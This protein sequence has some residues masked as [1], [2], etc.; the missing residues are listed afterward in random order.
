MVTGQVNT[1]ANAK[2]TLKLWGNCVTF[3][4]IP[5]KIKRVR[6][7]RLLKAAQK[8]WLTEQP[9]GNGRNSWGGVKSNI[10]TRARE[11]AEAA[12]REQV[13]RKEKLLNITAGVGLRER[14]AASGRRSVN[15]A[16]HGSP[17]EDSLGYPNDCIYIQPPT[18]EPN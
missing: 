12:K 6:R 1:H 8:Q 11:R 10:H 3:W 15:D 4:K 2:K 5:G 13:A 18:P 17:C 7:R 16:Y 9:N 14:A